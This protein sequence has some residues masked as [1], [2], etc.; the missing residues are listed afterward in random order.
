MNACCSPF[1]EGHAWNGV[2]LKYSEC[3]GNIVR[4]I[5]CTAECLSDLANKEMKNKQIL[6]KHRVVLVIVLV[7][8]N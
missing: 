4:V 8:F 2:E 6:Q 5:I 3:V 1:P 7:I